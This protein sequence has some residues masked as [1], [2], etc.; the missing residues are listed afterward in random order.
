MKKQIIVAGQGG[1]G[2]LELGNNLCNYELLKGKHVAFTPSYGPES[3][4]GKVKCY[5][6]TSDEVIDSPIVEA[7]DY[8]IVMNT[9]SMDYVNLLK[10]GGKLLMNSSLI[11][12]ES[13]RTD[14]QVYKVPA[15]EI[16]YNLKNLELE[17]IADTKIS[18]NSVMFGAYLQFAG[19][20]FDQEAAHKVFRQS[21]L[22]RKAKFEALNMQALINGYAAARDILRKRVTVQYPVVSQENDG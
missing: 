11:S 15:T 16:A 2:V 17:G 5:V 20:E 9:A 10:P 14:V 22:G 6:T 3:R 13:Q 7:P 18:T 4:G 8:L 19:E 1:Q 21:L 12:Q